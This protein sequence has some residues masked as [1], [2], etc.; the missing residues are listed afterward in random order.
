MKAKEANLFQFMR[1]P[2]QFII[3]IYQ[4]QYSWKYR[5]CEKF[6]SD[7][8]RVGKENYSGH[9]VGSVVYVESG[10]Y[11]HSDVPQLVVIDGQQ[12]LTTTALLVLALIDVVNRHENSVLEGTNAKKLKTYYLCNDAEEGE[13]F[14][15]LILTRADKLA[16]KALVDGT[17]YD[18]DS[19]CRVIQNYR[20]F[21]DK[22]NSVPIEDLQ[23]I[24]SGLQKLN[25]VDIALDRD[26]DNPQLIFESLNSTG[27]DLSQADLIRNFVLMG[28]EPVEQERW[29]NKYWYPMEGLFGHGEHLSR[30]NQFMRDYLTLKTGNTP[31]IN[32]VYDAFKRYLVHADEEAEQV[33]A[34][35][36][37]HAQWYVC[38][39]QGQE[40]NALLAS[41]FN[42]LNSYKVDV[43]Y[44]LL[45]ACYRDYAEGVLPITEF[46]YCVRL[47]ESYVFRRAICDIPTNSLNKTFSGFSKKLDRENYVVSFEA[48]LVKLAAY[49]RFPTDQEV[50]VRLQTKDMY[51]LRS[52]LYWLQRLENY[53]RKESVQVAEYTVEHVMP[54]STP[55]SE[56]WKIALGENWKDTFETRLNVLGNLTLTGYN[57]ELSNKV[58]EEKRDM[59]GGFATSPLKMNRGLAMV[60]VWDQQAIDE[61]TKSLT[62]DLLKVWPY[63]NVVEGIQTLA[64]ERV[65]ET[66]GYTIEDHPYIYSGASKDLYEKFRE[67]VLGLNGDIREEFL[68]QYVAFKRRTNFVDVIPKA[69]WLC[70]TINLRYA[71]LDD[72]AGRCRDVSDVGRWGNGDVELKISKVNDIPYA[73]SIV[74]QA[75]DAQS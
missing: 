52:K 30:F 74:K 24:Y 49:R 3:P 61:R 70:L 73:M 34:D 19:P 33:V 6:W 51:N 18:E 48:E 64:E 56:G 31:N 71:D 22:L 46:E 9:F 26:R 55:K 25:F 28:L 75:Y 7:V 53:G 39:A 69:T 43:S 50:T 12:R 14:Y 36:Y 11:S 23:Y 44:P 20:F 63:P 17:P 37:K 8:Y 72:P 41:A 10:L 15:K 47:I 38:F 54:Q 35:V 13:L 65:S 40:K 62:R 67:E 21:R 5:E 60:D 68:K 42:D 16:L 2:A 32:A 58:F 27:L 29:Y 45:L 57:S 59:E 4:R 66:N 1:K